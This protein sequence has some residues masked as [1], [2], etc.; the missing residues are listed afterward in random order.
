MSV[1][2]APKNSSFS[3]PEVEGNTAG[4]KAVR[5]APVGSPIPLQFP[6]SPMR[7]FAIEIEHALHVPM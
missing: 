4:A 5:E 3:A 1:Y 6:L 7:F 2:F